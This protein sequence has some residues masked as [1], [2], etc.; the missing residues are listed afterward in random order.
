MVVG[1]DLAKTERTVEVLGRL[2]AR[3]EGIEPHPGIADLA[4]VIDDPL[5]ERAAEPAA[6]EARLDPEPLHLADP[7]LER[8]QPDATDRLLAHLGEQ[9]AP[10]GR[11]ITAGQ[12][13]QLLLEP[14]EAEIDLEPV[15]VGAK[16]PPHLLELGG[17]PRLDQ[18]H[19]GQQAD[20]HRPW[21]VIAIRAPRAGNR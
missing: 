5:G 1:R 21:P 10:R 8:A 20:A 7:G 18:L 19:V 13:G 12:R 11:R 15:G 17:R 3:R 2:H 9:Q 4:R 14:L 6:A 16:Q